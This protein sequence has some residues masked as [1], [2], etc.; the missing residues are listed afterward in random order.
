MVR[1][2]I[3]GS[4]EPAMNEVIRKSFNSATANA[5]PLPPARFVVV[6]EMDGKIVGHT[7]VRPMLFHMGNALVRT[8]NLHMIGTDPAYQH[9]G[10][11]HAMMD[12]ANEIS[13]NEHLAISILETPMTEFY[14]L[15]GWE[16]IGYRTVIVVNRED[17]QATLVVK[18]DS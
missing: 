6:A 1:T 2:F 9:Q 7:S 10:I 13:S 17:I 16:V 3:P 4:D 5:Y 15:K 11:G 12:K 8:A 14:S 18:S